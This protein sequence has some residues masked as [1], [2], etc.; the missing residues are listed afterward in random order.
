MN[1][2]PDKIFPYIDKIYR[3]PN[4]ID[5][6]RYKGQVCN[7]WGLKG[8]RIFRKIKMLNKF[9]RHTYPYTRSEIDMNM[10]IARDL[11]AKNLHWW[12]SCH[13]E[14]Y[15]GDKEFDIVVHNGYDR[16][17]V[18]LGAIYKSYKHYG[19]L[20]EKLIAKGYKVASIGFAREYIKG[21]INL[22]GIPFAQQLGVIKKAKLYID[23]DS[24]FY[25]AANCLEV[26]NI[27]IFCATSRIKNFDKRFHKFS[28]IVHGVFEC[29]NHCQEKR[30][31]HNCP[32]QLKC[33]KF[34]PEIVLK[35]IERKLNS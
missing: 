27:V 14:P 31:F 24:A 3:R 30:Q 21:T 35:A 7:L 28:T 18:G 8:Q 11:G 32:Y 26:P 12:S 5:Q 15:T 33:R 29:A 25:H 4:D 19:K 17:V 1:F 13:Y 6:K 23:N 2:S 9:R 22:S 16:A 20:V 10:D 34:S